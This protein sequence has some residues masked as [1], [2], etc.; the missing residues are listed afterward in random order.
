M[1]G[2]GPAFENAPRGLRAAKSACA[3]WGPTARTVPQHLLGSI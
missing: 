3:D 2:D 1:P